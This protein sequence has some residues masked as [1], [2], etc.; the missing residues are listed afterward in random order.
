MNQARIHL[1]VN[2]HIKK[3]FASMAKKSI[4][5]ILLVDDDNLIRHSCR[6][7][8]ERYGYAVVYADSGSMAKEVWG[9]HFKEIELLITDYD[10]PDMNGL[11][12]AAMCRE[13][14]PS[15]G[16]LLISGRYHAPIP[17]SIG[18]LSKPFSRGELINM[19]NRYLIPGTTT[20]SNTKP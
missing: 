20:Y 6:F 5:L 7:I 3:P 10:M 9:K 11:Q 2:K 18:F 16:V 8:L 1:T 14:K 17:N 4:P 13:L 15:L 19:V 12:L